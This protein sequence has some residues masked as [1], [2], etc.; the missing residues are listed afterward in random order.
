VVPD[1]RIGGSGWEG[2]VSAAL[3]RDV[4]CGKKF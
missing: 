4:L 3:K 2:V 1:I